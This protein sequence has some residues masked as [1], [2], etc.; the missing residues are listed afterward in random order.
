MDDA[1]KLDLSNKQKIVIAGFTI[2]LR[3][4]DFDYRWYLLISLQ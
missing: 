4:G 1:E 3:L 2:L